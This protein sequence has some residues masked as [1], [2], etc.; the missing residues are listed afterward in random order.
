MRGWLVACRAGEKEE[1][2]DGESSEQT[3]GV[4]ATKQTKE[5]FLIIILI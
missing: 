1:R 2:R 3:A 4:R 5:F